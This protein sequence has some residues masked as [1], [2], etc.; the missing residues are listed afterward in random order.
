MTVNI[1]RSS[2]KGAVYSVLK[3]AIMTLQLVPGTGISTQ[4]VASKLNVSRTPVREA[5]IRLEKEGL[6]DI[7]PQKETVVSRIDM[8]RVLQERFIREA[9]EV[10][11]VDP[12]LEKCGPADFSL[13]RENIEKQRECFREKRHHEFIQYDNNMHSQFFETAG[14]QLAW[15]M[16]SECNGH[17]DRF[18]LMAVRVEEIQL[19]VILQHEKIIDMLE[20]G[21]AEQ[22]KKE[23]KAHLSKTRTEKDVLLAQYPEYFAQEGSQNGI[24]L[25]TL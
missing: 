19:G 4:E 21:E 8:H 11:V 2:T 5:F 17:Y 10:A 13:L 9:M 16:V 14:Q 23:L 15:E 3:E 18:R 24:L 20:R 1:V 6:V 12:F 7:Y 22:A 25:G